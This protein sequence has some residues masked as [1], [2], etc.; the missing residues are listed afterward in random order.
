MQNAQTLI[1]VVAVAGLFWMILMFVLT[2][3]GYLRRTWHA[4]ELALPIVPLHTA[5]HATSAWLTMS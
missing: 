3:S 2:F 5:A 1:R 4:A